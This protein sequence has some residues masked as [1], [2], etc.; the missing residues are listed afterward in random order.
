MRGRDS[1][2]W[3]A[4]DGAQVVAARL[5]QSVIQQY[6]GTATARSISSSPASPWYQRP[7]VSFVK[8]FLSVSVELLQL[9]SNCDRWSPSRSDVV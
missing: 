7:T 2:G 8:R 5:A 3:E 6:K 4:E 1:G 9:S